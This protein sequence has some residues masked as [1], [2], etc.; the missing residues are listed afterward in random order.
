VPGTRGR[1]PRNP[2]RRAAFQTGS[3][4][5]PVPA[6]HRASTTEEDLMNTR[7]IAIAALVIAI[8]LVLIL[9]L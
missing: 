5:I 2:D 4:R 9:V 7:T 3:V 1:I 8:I 6:T